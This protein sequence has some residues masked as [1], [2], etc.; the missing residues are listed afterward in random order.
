[1]FLLSENDKFILFLKNS[2]LG[3]VN[4][5]ELKSLKLNKRVYKS[6]IDQFR[7]YY[8]KEYNKNFVS[9]FLKYVL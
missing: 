8:S 7:K 1:M 3:L 4:K 9:I 2:K 5:R 6:D